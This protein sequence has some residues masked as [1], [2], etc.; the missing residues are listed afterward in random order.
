MAG[1]FEWRRREVFTSTELGSA[2]VVAL[3]GTLMLL[4]LPA[5][6]ASAAAPE[7][8]FGAIAYSDANGTYA[9]ALADSQAHAE[10]A[11]AYKCTQNGGTYCKAYVWFQ[12]NWGSLAVGQ[13]VANFGT[14]YGT[15]RD[16]A[17]QYAVKTCIS[18]GGTNCHVVYS[19]HTPNVSSNT[20]TG[21]SAAV[22]QDEAIPP[23]PQ[24]ISDAI[25][26]A[27]GAAVSCGIAWSKI[28]DIVSGLENLFNI[29]RGNL[30]Q[31]ARDFI[32]GKLC[33]SEAPEAAG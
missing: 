2:L 19:V 13:T 12:D 32:F 8:N 31:F 7:T 1:L 15:S 9:S 3:A 20:A 16:F 28:D 6:P 21:G 27:L 14:G 10:A 18:Y 11:A 23:I 29:S 5:G 25:E 33:L 17:D 22:T 4:G 30:D 26:K 24:D